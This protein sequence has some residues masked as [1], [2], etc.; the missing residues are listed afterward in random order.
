MKFILSEDS[1][2]DILNTTEFGEE[3]HKEIV[4]R[5]RKELK[6]LEDTCKKF[7]KD[8]GV[9][10]D[11][12]KI[13]ESKLNEEPE[14]QAIYDNRNSFYKKANYENEGKYTILYSYDTPVVK[15]DNETKEIYLLPAWNYS[16]TTLRHVREFL[17]QN[18]YGF[19]SKHDIEKKF[20][21]NELATSTSEI[22]LGESKLNEDLTEE[23]NLD[24]GTAGLI[25]DLI[26]KTWD[27]I[28][29]YS[30]AIATLENEDGD[31]EVLSIL[32]E[33]CSQENINVGQLEKALN[34]VD[35]M[36]TLKD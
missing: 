26:K 6:P 12:P 31:K 24:N 3:E 18:G 23:E 1:N 14:L 16:N 9:K 7:L 35:P 10:E 36:S 29:S 28:D 11:L 5:A 32:N 17:Q 25:R 21:R 15:M 20:S 22:D 34:I 4:D 27:A 2:N 30:S 19:M 33:I 13:V 8:N